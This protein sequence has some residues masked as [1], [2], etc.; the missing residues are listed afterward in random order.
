M[1]E[2]INHLT[3]QIKQQNPLILNLT[4]DVT[5]D[6]VAN[7]LL[8]LGASPIMSKA[9]KELECLI[10]IANAVVINIGTLDDT[11]INLCKKACQLA[12]QN[13]KPLILDPVGAGATGYRT[14]T[15]LQLLK[16]FK[17]DLIR[18][19][20]SEI[21]ALAKV[22]NHTKGVDSCMTTQDAI[23]SGK[24]IASQY[25]TIVV[26]SGETDA[27]IT[28]DE[29]QLLICGS[30]M[31]SKITGTGCL[32]T[33]VLGAFAVIAQDRFLAICAATKFYGDCGGRAALNAKGT[34]S[35]KTLFLD[36]LSTIPKQND[37]A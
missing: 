31:M 5:M 32:L 10:Q 18:G 19:N 24:T 25:Q 8:S 22:V 9:E 33:A 12:N 11:F 27:V 2:T 29:M 7:G 37:Y 3:T 36:E 16:Q 34:G 20:A 21:M 1:Y 6:F 23:T 17:F 26:I 30:P 13:K 15:C 35:F 14:Q 28:Q 4:N